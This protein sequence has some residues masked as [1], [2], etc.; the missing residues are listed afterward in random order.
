MS[1]LALLN[2]SENPLY[3][4]TKVSTITWQWQFYVETYPV[5]FNQKP[6]LFVITI[7]VNQKN[8]MASLRVKM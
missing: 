7:V 5:I 4:K 2:V 3:G 6:H 1:D 8:L